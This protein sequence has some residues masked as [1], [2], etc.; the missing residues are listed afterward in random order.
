[1][2]LFSICGILFEGG[3]CTNMY[4]EVW[5]RN[6][7]EI[8]DQAGRGGGENDREEETGVKVHCLFGWVGWVKKAKIGFP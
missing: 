7:Q 5:G 8:V 1:M 4:H 2:I 6:M 3:P